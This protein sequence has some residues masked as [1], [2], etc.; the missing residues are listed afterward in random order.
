MKKSINLKEV[1]KIILDNR[2]QR[3]SDEQTYTILRE[4]YYDKQALAKLIKTTTTRQKIAHYKKW[5]IL[6][7]VLCILVGILYFVE[8]YMDIFLSGSF[9]IAFIAFDVFFIEGLLKYD[10]NAYWSVM[11]L[12]AFLCLISIPSVILPDS[13]SALTN[14][15]LILFIFNVILNI[16]TIILAFYLKR[17]LFIP[18]KERKLLRFE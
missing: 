13:F 6:L 7:I 15:Q 2:E 16:L 11:I 1:R 12:T 10:F 18:R 4:Q 5:N 3:I 8:C 14:L 9:F 17:K